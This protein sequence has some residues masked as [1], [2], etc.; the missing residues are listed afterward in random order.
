MSTRRGSFGAIFFA[1]APLLWG[2]G[3]GSG[4]AATGG[5][6]SGADPASTLRVYSTA[7][8]DGAP[9]PVRHTCDG[10]D[11]SPLLGWEGEPDETKSF[12]LVVDDPDAPGGTFVHWV[13]FDLDGTAAG[14]GEDAKDLGV[15]GEND[16]GTV[17]WRGPCPPRGAAHHYR[18][19]L[20]ALDVATLGLAAGASR[21]EVDAA[22]AGHVL[23]EGTLVGTY[24]RAA[25]R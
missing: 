18:F 25:Q 21:A 11:L 16:F 20:R 12:A 5:D 24:Q 13:L 17:G 6:G 10:D 7:F 19:Q 22:V 9:I 4:G 2:C 15:A 8:E 1:L 14:F 3:H 23:A